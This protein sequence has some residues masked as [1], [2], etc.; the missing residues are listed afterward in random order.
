MS[1]LDRFRE[2][3]REVPG[4]DDVDHR[5]FSDDLLSLPDEE[6]LARWDSISA[7]RAAGVVGRM[8]PLYRDFFRGRRVLE[9]GGGLGFDGLRFAAQG[10]HWTFADIVPSNLSVIRRIAALKGIAVECHLIG[11]DL[12]FEALRPDYDAIIVIGSIHHIPFDIAR[13][14]ALN[15]LSRLKVGG[16][17][18]ELVYPR[19]RWLRE[20]SM[21]FD[22]WGTRTDGER[23][24]WVEWHDIEK[25]R[26]RLYPAILTTVLDFELASN[27]H[28]WLDLRY[29]GMG[30][31]VDPTKFVDVVGQPVV[32]EGGNRNGWAFSGSKGAFRPIGRVDLRPLLTNLNAPFAVD[33]ILHINEGI[34][35]VGLVDTNN[36]YLADTEVILESTPDPRFVTLRSAETPSFL[37]FRNRH[38]D[39]GSTFVVRSARL[40]EA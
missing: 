33:L 1:A 39:H 9:L 17:W 11:E 31:T 40:R 35:G 4:G 20:G 5:V 8:E 21:P 23:T 30:R 14:E 26:R 13:S 3:W 37:V 15:A 28:R 12:S 27:S 32:L 22:T 16:R 24:P 10:A 18:I 34:V 38:E 25:V 6:F 7:R 29:T 19:E 36:Q 2:K